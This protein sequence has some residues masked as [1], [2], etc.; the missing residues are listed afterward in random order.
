LATG[1]II[2]IVLLR[3]SRMRHAFERADA[4]VG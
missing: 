4:G 1:L 3:S 2:M